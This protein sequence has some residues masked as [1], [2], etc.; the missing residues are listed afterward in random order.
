MSENLFGSKKIEPQAAPNAP[1]RVGFR[2]YRK[3][4]R[5]LA[6]DFGLRA[7]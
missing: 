3:G 1:L 2:M 7:T 6:D 5:A 4:K